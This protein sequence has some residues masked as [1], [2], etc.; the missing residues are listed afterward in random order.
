MKS[1]QTLQYTIRKVP[2]VVDR[3]LRKRAQQEGKSI[4]QVALEALMKGAG[5]TAEPVIHHDL[6]HLAGTWVDDPSFDE[7][8]R[9]QHAV[10]EDLW[11]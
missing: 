4:N 1:M 8:I 3:T 7:A 2:V 10:D 9:A 5:V 11:K 6:D